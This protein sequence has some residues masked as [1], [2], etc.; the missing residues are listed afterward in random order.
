M[1]SPVTKRHRRS[2]PECRKATS[3]IYVHSPNSTI[4][5][6]GAISRVQAGY[7]TYLVDLRGNLEPESVPT[8][9]AECLRLLPNATIAAIPNTEMQVILSMYNLPIGAIAECPAVSVNHLSETTLQSS[10][11]SAILRK[12]VC[13]S[14]RYQ[15]H[16]Y[17][18]DL[19]MHSVHRGRRVKHQRERVFV[20]ISSTRILVKRYEFHEV[21]ITRRSA[22][23]FSLNFFPSEKC[24]ALLC[25]CALPLARVA[26][27][28]ERSRGLVCFLTDVVASTFGLEVRS[29]SAP[30]TSH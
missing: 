5:A 19:S 2:H 12:L 14:L 20:R 15:R 22:S 30:R 29:A 13:T 3:L 4:S 28:A 21:S 23:F 10:S 27:T 16:S 1:S 26:L 6:A 25:I 17:S 18:I 8:F 24:V 7:S 9:V 11:Q